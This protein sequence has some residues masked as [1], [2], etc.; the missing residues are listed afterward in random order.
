MNYDDIKPITATRGR[1]IK[2]VEKLSVLAAQNKPTNEFYPIGFPLF[3][4]AMDGGLRQGNL[5]VVSGRT[6]EGKTTFCQQ[7]SVNLS[8][9]GIPTLWFSYE[10]EP[11]Y[12]QENFYKITSGDI[13]VYSPIQLISNTIE[14][15]GRVIEE[16]WDEHA[17]KVVFIDHLHY[18]IPLIEAKNS[19]L[20]IGGIVRELKKLAISQRAVIFLIAHT[21]K[22]YQGEE[23]DLSS[24]RDSSLVAQEADFVYLIERKRKDRAN[25]LLQVVETEG[26]IFENSTKIQLAKNRKTGKLVFLN[27]E[28]IENKFSPQINYGNYKPVERDNE[29]AF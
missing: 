17:C 1:T 14:F 10:M 20:L 26:D 2:L 19:S 21:K 18:L 7:I 15:I 6:G 13:S 16:G 23:L 4:S 29:I 8:N 12:L 27:C 3:D 11:Y 25:K 5:V 22:I 9:A 28:F 24:I